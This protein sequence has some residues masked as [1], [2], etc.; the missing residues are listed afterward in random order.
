MD[1][2]L[3]ETH[4]LYQRTVREFCDANLAPIARTIDTE[5][6][7]P[8]GLLSSMGQLGMLGVMIPQQYGGPGGT[9][10]M[11]TIGAEEVGRADVSMAT[12]VYYLLCTGWS[13]LLAAHGSAACKQ[14]V[15]PKVASGEWFLGIA[16]TEPSGGSDI[17]AMRTTAVDKGDH[18]LL[19]GTKLFISGG[20][21]AAAH[22]GGHLTLARTSAPPSEEK[23]HLGLTL[24]YVDAGAPGVTVTRQT[25]MGRMGISTCELRYQDVRVPK[26]QVVGKADKGFLTLMEGFSTARILVAAACVGCAER[27]LELGMEYVKQREAFGRPIAKFEGIQFPLVDHWSRVQMVR[28]QI[29]KAAWMTDAHRAE[30]RFDLNEIS[31]VVAIG[32]LWAPQY[33]ADVARDV[34]TWF[35]AAGYTTDYELEM[36]LRGILSYVVGAEGALNVMRVIMAR[37]LLG[38]EF[39]PYR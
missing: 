18:Y 29:Y 19:N 33:A 20:T 27:F 2:S 26:D 36:G 3:D 10:V 17:A 37:E 31:K 32:K 39:L 25:N 16:T 21:E 24:M 12:A 14:R 9:T 35:G 23:G 6:R 38:K 13:S 7:I 5:E 4:Q 8:R 34:M 30:G 11:A 28:D 22:G 15:L 1:F